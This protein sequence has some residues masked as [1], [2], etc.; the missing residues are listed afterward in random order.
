MNLWDFIRSLKWR[1]L[2]SLFLLCLGNLSKVWPT[3]KAT[4][5]SISLSSRYY[6]PAHRHN[7][8]ANAF[9]HAIWN[10]L[11][12]DACITDK[13]DI[14]EILL[15]TKKIT[16]LHEELFPNPPL[17]RAMD[18]HNNAVGRKIFRDYGP[19]KSEEVVAVLRTKSEVS[20]KIGSQE[21]LD[22]IQAE[23]LVHIINTEKNER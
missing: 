23:N 3:W 10:Y 14:E 16:H 2:Y 4:K 5:K 1:Q 21:D 6:G 8:A 11:V 12:A 18:L 20:A 19:G 13:T 17:A 22:G 7:T 15:W 9:R